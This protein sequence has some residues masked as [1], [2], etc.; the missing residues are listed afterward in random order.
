MDNVAVVI[1]NYNGKSH[2]ERFLPSVI[3]HSG[4]CQI[5]VAD[6]ASTDDSVQ[7][8][9]S[10]FPTIRLIQLSHNTGY[11]GGY[12]Q[13][14]RQIEA[15]YFVLLNSDV[16][17]TANWVTPIIQLM[18]ADDHI[19]A[20]Q[21]KILAFNEPTQFE[22]AGAAGGFIDTFGYPFCRGRIFDSLET[23]K[24]QYDN[25]IDI[26]W[27]TGACLFIR[28]TAYERAGGLDEDFF[29][30]MEEIDLCWRLVSLG[31]K[32]K[33]VSESVVYHV[34]GGTLSKINPK[35][36]YLNFRNGLALLI[37]NCTKSDLILKLPV[38]MV[39]DT[40]A[41]LKFLIDRKPTHS[42]AIIKAYLG[43]ISRFQRY[44]EQRRSI[45]KTPIK[46]HRSIVYQN[47]LV[48]SYYLRG[49]KRFEELDF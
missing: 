6:N 25:T 22:Y 17:V 24:G 44:L 42:L 16:E 31:Y 11:S 14:L 43:A 38:R 30:H 41:M 4:Q 12:N 5:I 10:S 20:C 26:F 33:Y 34:G 13:A 19:A 46:K 36:T 2:L 40:A 29:A 21:P 49:K 48:F 9:K 23:D 37:K 7:F 18:E 32:N 27:A 15:D 45:T 1:L 8:L 28:R 3:E 47:S 35:K 39:L